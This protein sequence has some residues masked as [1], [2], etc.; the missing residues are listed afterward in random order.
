MQANFWP[1]I[2]GSLTPCLPAGRKAVILPL[3]SFGK[4][5]RKRKSTLLL[6]VF[7][8]FFR[9]TTE[10]VKEGYIFRFVINNTLMRTS[11]VLPILCCFLLFL[12]SY[13]LCNVYF[14]Y[15][16]YNS[17]CECRGWRARRGGHEAKQAVAAWLPENRAVMSALTG[18]DQL[19][20][21]PHL[22][23]QPGARLP[24]FPAMRNCPHGRHIHR[25]GL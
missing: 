14:V 22:R 10:F 25:A 6:V 2:V 13:L 24:E 7:A 5:K 21:T 8:F 15:I 16:L 11:G 4:V 23:N 20:R 12:F 3:A 19:A 17:D 1:F 9:L 18:P